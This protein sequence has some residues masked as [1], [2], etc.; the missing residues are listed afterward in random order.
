MLREKRGNGDKDRERGRK[1]WERER[2]RETK[3][4]LRKGETER[5]SHCGW[6]RK[7]RRN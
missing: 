4:W 7:W 2:E 3:M 6:R 5:I 1:R